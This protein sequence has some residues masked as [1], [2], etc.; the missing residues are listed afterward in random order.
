MTV[1]F[2]SVIN[3]TD[4]SLDAPFKVPQSKVLASSFSFFTLLAVT[5]ELLPKI[6]CAST[7]KSFSKLCVPGSLS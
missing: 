2:N 6:A 5:E 4:W 7:I 1:P 3:K